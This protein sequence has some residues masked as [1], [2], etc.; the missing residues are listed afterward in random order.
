[1]NNTTNNF[2]FIQDIFTMMATLK[3]T[4]KPLLL[5]KYPN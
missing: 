4:T 5:M 1:L 2:I 3:A